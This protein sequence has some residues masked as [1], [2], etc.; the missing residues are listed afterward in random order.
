[1]VDWGYTRWLMENSR[2]TPCYQC[3]D[4]HSRCHSECPKYLEFKDLKE[5][6]SEE[7]RKFSLCHKTEKFEKAMLKKVKHYDH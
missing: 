7:L 2:K 3:E 4:R 1:M 6:E 5:K